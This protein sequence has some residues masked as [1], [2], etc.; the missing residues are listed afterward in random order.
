M[1]SLCLYFSLSIYLSLY[2]SL[3][4]FISLYLSLSLSQPHPHFGTSFIA[5]RLSPPFPSH[6]SALRPQSATAAMIRL[7]PP[8]PLGAAFEPHAETVLT[9]AGRALTVPSLCD[10]AHAAGL[11]IDP[12]IMYQ[13]RV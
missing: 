9:A 1:F 8:P 4:L 10:M 5:P 3:S 7:T 2:F 6:R 12:D 13:A 11:E